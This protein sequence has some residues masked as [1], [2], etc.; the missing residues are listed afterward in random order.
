M[1]AKGA[2]TSSHHRPR[3][4]RPGRGSGRPQPLPELARKAIGVRVRAVRESQ[5]RSLG[6]VAERVNMSEGSLGELE[7]GETLNPPIGTLLR[8]MAA[9]GVETIE[10]LLGPPEFPSGELARLV[11]NPRNTSVPTP[12]HRPIQ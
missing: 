3:P 2:N 11:T 8:L 5:G 1:S 4:P 9:L 6:W 12:S 10:L 7:R